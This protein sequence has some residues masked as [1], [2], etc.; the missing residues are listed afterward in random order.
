[1][2]SG[3]RSVRG[4]G[5][6]LAALGIF[7]MAAQPVG[8]AG[9][10]FGSSLD[11]TMFPD[12]AYS[13]QNCQHELTGQDGTAKCTWI[14]V[15]PASGNQPS[16]PANGKITKIKLIAGKGGSFTLYLAQKSGSK[17]KLVRKGPKITYGTDQ[18]SPDC[19]IQKFNISPLTVHSGDYLAVQMAKGSIMQ[20]NSGSNATAL[21]KPPLAIGG[22]Y[23]SPTDYSGC[24]LLLQAVLS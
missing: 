18:C 5:A 4:I 3:V 6:V 1:M 15:L 21:Y 24:R 12:N 2:F 22:S 14:L 10:K 13:G 17:F 7:F 11:T 16:S 19:H 23:A 20:C 9:A 8:A